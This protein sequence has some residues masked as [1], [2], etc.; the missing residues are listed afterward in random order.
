MNRKIVLALLLL[1]ASDKLLAQNKFKEIDEFLEE[2][3]G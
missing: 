3:C 1:L 2:Q